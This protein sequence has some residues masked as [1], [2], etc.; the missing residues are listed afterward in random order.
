MITSEGWADKKTADIPVVQE[1][2]FKVYLFI[3]LRLTF[4]QHIQLALLMIGRCGFGFS[5]NWSTPARAP[6][7][8]MSLQEA[9]RVVGDTHMIAIVLPKWVQR[10]PFRRLAFTGFTSFPL[11][12]NDWRR[13]RE[14]RQAH[15]Q[16]MDFMQNQVAE[17]KAE[18]TAGLTEGKNIDAFTMLVK[19]NEEEA[20]K[21]QLDDDELVSSVSTYPKFTYGFTK[22][23]NVFIMLFAGHGQFPS[24]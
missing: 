1:Y 10:L 21:F 13:L 3:L 19:A 20:G 24:R 6:D 16:L 4:D 8:S 11:W 15:E 23:G 14:A 18:I 17:R 5:F 12:L 22:I 9:L 7:G 2:T